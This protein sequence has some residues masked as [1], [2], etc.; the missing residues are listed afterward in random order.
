MQLEMQYN[1]SIP[2]CSAEIA[3]L[4][5]GQQASIAICSQAT[6][7]DQL[8][9]DVQVILPYYQSLP[10]DKVGDLQHV[11]DFDVPKV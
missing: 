8:L 2:A 3:W 11:M 7:I 1:G 10:E 6:T 4:D 5:E 9:A